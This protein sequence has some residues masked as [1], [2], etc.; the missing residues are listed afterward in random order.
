MSV[1]VVLAA[2]MAR[3]TALVE[4]AL[5]SAID[6]PIDQV[7]VDLLSPIG[8]G[9]G[10]ETSSTATASASDRPGGREKSEG[11]T[12]VLA[13]PASANSRGPSFG[14]GLSN[15]LADD[16]RTAF[17]QAPDGQVG[18]FNDDKNPPGLDAY[19]RTRPLVP[20]ASRSERLQWFSSSQADTFPL[21]YLRDLQLYPSTHVHLLAAL[22]RFPPDNYTDSFYPSALLPTLIRIDLLESAPPDTHQRPHP[23]TASTYGARFS[24]LLALELAARSRRGRSLVLYK[25]PLV[26]LDPSVGESA[27]ALVRVPVPGVRRIGRRSALAMRVSC[28]RSG[29]TGRPGA[30]RA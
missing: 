17:G 12:Y 30:T 15:W 23:Q 29:P 2:N 4:N 11:A 18:A 6:G 20:S 1:P 3:A 14:P 19:V 13:P 26:L 8:P 25:L 7:W 24:H 27:G 5:G 10:A 28:A 21:Q 22:P 9:A 16:A